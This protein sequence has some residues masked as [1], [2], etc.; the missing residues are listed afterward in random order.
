MAGMASQQEM[1]RL[2]RVE[3]REFD[4]LFSELMIEHHEGGIQMARAEVQNGRSD[5]VRELAQGM[6]NVQQVEVEK[7]EAWRT[8]WRGDA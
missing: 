2:R 8:E 1:S 6:V 3:G 7:M 5:K 4:L